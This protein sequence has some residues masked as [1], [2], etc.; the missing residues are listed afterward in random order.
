MWVAYGQLVQLF[1]HVL[2]VVTVFEMPPLMVDLPPDTVFPFPPTMDVVVDPVPDGEPDPYDRDPEDVLLRQRGHDLRERESARCQ[3][4]HDEA[5]IGIERDEALMP[6]GTDP[7]FP[8]GIHAAPRWTPLSSG[9]PFELK[10][11]GVSH[12][13]MVLRAPSSRQDTGGHPRGRGGGG[14]GRSGSTRSPHRVPLSAQLTC[15]S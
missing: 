12:T 14:G 9:R 7:T 13:P 15:V 4:E 8:A 3:D 11:V 2:P 6:G 1:A 10:L 5:A